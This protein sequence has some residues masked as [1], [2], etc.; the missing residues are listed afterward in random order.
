MVEPIELKTTEQNEIQYPLGYTC[1]ASGL[2]KTEKTKS[3]DYE[4]I[5]IGDPITFLGIGCAEDSNGW[6]SLLEWKS[7]D[8]LT[9]Q[10]LLLFSALHEGKNEWAKH[11]A[12]RGYNIIPKYRKLIENYLSEMATIHREKILSFPRRIGWLGSSYVLPSRVIGNADAFPQVT[13]TKSDLYSPRGTKEEWVRASRYCIGNIHFE[14]ALAVAFAGSLMSLADIEF[15][16]TFHLLGSSSCGK[17]TCQRIACS[18]WGGRSHKISWNTTDNGLEGIAVRSNDNLL[19]LDDISQANDRVLDKT[20]YMIANGEGKTRADRN[21]N[22]RPTK[23]W[24]TIALSSGEESLESKC[25]EEVKAGQTVRFLDIPVERDMLTTLHGFAS[26][27][28]IAKT[29]D[30]LTGKNYGFAGEQFLEYVVENY[31]SL[32]ATLPDRVKALAKK[33]RPADADTQVERVSQYFALVQCAGELAQEAGALPK[34]MDIAS[35]VEKFVSLWLER[36]GTAG[37]MEETKIVR[38]VKMFLL[39]YGDS[40]FSLVGEECRSNTRYGYI[41]RGRD[42]KKKYMIDEGLFLSEVA[43]SDNK[44]LVYSAL[45]K[46]GMLAGEGGKPTATFRFPEKT[47]N[48][49]CVA[50]R[51][52]NEELLEEPVEEVVKVPKTGFVFETNPEDDIFRELAEAV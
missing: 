39:K 25:F 34:E 31:E 9:R 24:K 50:L 10:Y 33:L 41:R 8:G 51:M 3:G 43:K 27:E 49:R 23:T 17:S 15:G 29:I 14:F 11:L 13:L 37:N 52:P 4:Q 26:A 12:D 44:K 28:D 42:G 18:V 21:A 30:S 46:A 48:T 38:R 7:P 35:C 5:R 45:E 40:S 32:S 1:N 19:V 22:D 6:G 36:R 47:K 2:W 16:S 20:S